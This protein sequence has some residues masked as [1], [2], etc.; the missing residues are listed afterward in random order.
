LR[1]DG[2]GWVRPL[3][4]DTTHGQLYARHLKLDDGSEPQPLDVITVDLAE[5]RP[6]P[7]QPE[8]WWIGAEPWVLWQRPA[9]PEL[10][11]VLQTGMDRSPL[12]LGSAERAIA[13]GTAVSAS[14]ALVA[15]Y[16]LRWSSGRDLQYRQQP[17]AL[18]K[19]GGNWYRLPVTD[20][21]WSPVIARHLAGQSGWHKSEDAGLPA[22][23]KIWLTVSLGEP[24]NGQCYKL[25]AGIV[26]APQRNA[27]RKPVTSASRTPS[28]P[29]RRAR[30]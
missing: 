16:V 27:A 22:N 6:S 8:N 5:P 7:G 12:L 25:V 17:A 11:R 14:L 20:P 29:A 28:D 10:D 3:A 15:P 18:F 4:R 19:L 21:L 1:A 23:T 2:K 24:F 13:A 9:G 30:P 26:L